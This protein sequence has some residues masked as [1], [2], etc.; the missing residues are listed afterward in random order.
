MKKIIRILGISLLSIVLLM[1][2]VPVAFKGK[3]KE[4]EAS[5]FAGCS[6]LEE[7]IFGE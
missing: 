2:I 1:A 3:I 4:I 5:A 7:V 6:A